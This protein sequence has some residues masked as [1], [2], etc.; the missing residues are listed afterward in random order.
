MQVSQNWLKLQ[1][2]M[3][4]T[5]SSKNALSTA[6][7]IPLSTKKKDANARKYVAIDCEMVGIGSDGVNSA[8][9]RVSVV[10][11]E[12]EVLLDEYV[13]PKQRVTDLR[14]KVSG[15]HFHH[16]KTG[17]DFEEVQ[18][19]VAEIIK[20]KVLVGHAVQNDLKVLLLGHPHKDIRDTS[21]YKEFR[22][23]SHGRTPGLKLLAKSVLNKSIQDGSHCSVEDART[24]MSLYKSCR[25][26]WE[27]ALR[28][29]FHSRNKEK[30]TEE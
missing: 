12:G 5:D 28:A 16:V 15:I 19:K 2:E 21:K 14:T 23:F 11:Y 17:L 29:K 24:A 7:T 22:R 4:S 3:K 20:G 8:L 6:K 9:A 27:A 30:I 13:K 10:D 26:E 1:Q 18:K 25:K